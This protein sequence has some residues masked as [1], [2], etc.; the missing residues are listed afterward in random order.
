[1]LLTLPQTLFQQAV[2]SASSVIDKRNV[3]FSDGILITVKDGVAEFIGADMEREARMI[4]QAHEHGDCLDGVAVVSG[5]KLKDL[6]KTAPNGCTVKLQ[7]KK[8]DA[9]TFVLTF[10]GS[11]SRFSLKNIGDSAAYPTIDLGSESL[12]RFTVS[13]KLLAS[14]LD[15]VVPSCAVNDVRYY[16]NGI[17]VFA[18]NDELTIEATDGHRLS[19]TKVP[20]INGTGNKEAERPYILPRKTALDVIKLAKG[21]DQNVELCFNTNHGV[22]TIGDSTLITKLIDGRFPDTARV[23]PRSNSVHCTVN[24]SN[25]LSSL[26]R[27]SILANE[28]F[29]GVKITFTNNEMMIN[30]SNSE[31]DEASEYVDCEV[32]T[33]QN[34]EIGFNVVYFTD[35]L[36]MYECEQVILQVNDHSTSILMSDVDN[37]PLIAVLMPMRL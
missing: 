29:R 32:E 13:A 1:M 37:G 11:R 12:N 4:V 10:S 23:I 35:A 24:R 3:L 7:V 28:K 21:K 5:K 36:K 34:I 6:V 14:A 18:M 8:D 22:L 26:N 27:A 15:S 19:Q 33:A 30:S 20:F 9:N 31:Q 16:L 17:N 25:L 2:D